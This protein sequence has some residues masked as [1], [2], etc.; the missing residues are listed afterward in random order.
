MHDHWANIAM[1]Q[2]DTHY[3]LVIEEHGTTEMKVEINGTN[4]DWV[5]LNEFGKHGKRQGGKRTDDL[6]WE[7]L[8]QLAENAHF[9]TEGDPH[10]TNLR[11]GAP[12]RLP[13]VPATP[14]APAT[15]HGREDRAAAGRCA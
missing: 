3:R 14:T 7:L 5:N 4:R 15:E 13:A 8:D 10:V 2:A 12:I 9:G 6:R 11:R 1:H